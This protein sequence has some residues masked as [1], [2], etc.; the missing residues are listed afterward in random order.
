M[1]QPLTFLLYH[2]GKIPRYLRNAIEHVRIFNP[3][4]EIMLITDGIGD[5]S[6]L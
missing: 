1:K 6:M 4:A 2:Y 5:V 3:T